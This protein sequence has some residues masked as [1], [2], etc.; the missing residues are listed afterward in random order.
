MS[1]ID[2]LLPHGAPGVPPPAPAAHAV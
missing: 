1:P 2:S